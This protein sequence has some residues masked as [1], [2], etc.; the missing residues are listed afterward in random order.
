MFKFTIACLAA[1][2]TAQETEEEWTYRY[3]GKGW[4]SWDAAPK[5]DR[6]MS[7]ILEDTTGADIDYS[8]LEDFFTQRANI[9]T[10]N[11]NDE[12]KGHKK[13]LHQQGV[14]APVQWV[15]SDDNIYTGLFAGA[16]YGFM[17]LSDSGFLV[18][19]HNS[20]NP[21][22]ALKFLVDGDESADLLFAIDFK[23]QS[24]LDFFPTDDAG[25]Y[26]PFT[27]HPGVPNPEDQPC[28]FQTSVRKL[29]EAAGNFV[30]STGT[31]HFS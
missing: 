2:A 6:L 19:D 27:T 17:R 30:F 21:S 14:I 9:T 28:S 1:L 7:E 16:E 10:C 4:K 15:A 23:N 5:H 25:D 13:T 20:S 12:V 8:L 31:G 26:K 3:S 29:I 24:T 11:R 18:E 22:A